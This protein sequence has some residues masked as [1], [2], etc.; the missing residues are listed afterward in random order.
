MTASTF[1]MKSR[2]FA[3]HHLTGGCRYSQKNAMEPVK[4]QGAR[5][6]LPCLPPLA[7]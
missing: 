7:N 1:E 6:F 2:S 5:A 4:A 3:S